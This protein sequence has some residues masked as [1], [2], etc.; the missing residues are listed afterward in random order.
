[1]LSVGAISA[2]AGNYYL[3]L[4]REDYYTKEDEKRGIWVGSGAD[5][6]NLKGEINEQEFKQILQGFSA[7]GSQKL[8]QNAG[9]DN[10]GCAWDL[11]FS[12]PKSVSIIFAVSDEDVRKVIEK[13][14]FEAV[15]E[16]LKEV[17]NDTFTR[18]GKGG[19]IYDKVD[20][21]CVAFEH[22]T[23][24]SVSKEVMPDMNLHTHI[25]VM[26]V[27]LSKSDGK[28]RSIKSENFYEKQQIYGNVYR[29]NLAKNLTLLNFECERKGEF[30]EVKGISKE[31]IEK[32]SKR[33]EQVKEQTKGIEDKAQKAKVK[34]RG[35]T[36][37]N[38]YNRKD[39]FSYWQAECKEFG[40]TSRDVLRLTDQERE[41]TKSVNEEAKKCLAVSV[42]KLTTKK[43]VFSKADL[44]K[45]FLQESTVHGIGSKD[46]KNKVNEFLQNKAFLVSENKNKDKT[47]YTLDKKTA[48]EE[49]KILSEKQDFK[50]QYSLQITEY[51]KSLEKKGFKVIGVSF[52]NETS[53]F[54]ETQTG[55]KTR[56]LRKTNYELQKG[57]ENK[58]DL[59]RKIKAEFKYA[60]YQISKDT[61]DKMLGLY[62]KPSSKSI[63]NLKY[64]TWQISKAH[65]NYLDYQL[66]REHFRVDEKTVVIF[67]GKYTEKNTEVESLF[68]QVE[69]E[70]GKVVTSA[71]IFQEQKQVQE[72]QQQQNQQAQAQQTQNQQQQQQQTQTQQT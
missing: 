59:K 28:T 69:A 47:L 63:H 9:K 60:T 27:G 19:K 62:H 33:T 23:S 49:K 67:D 58:I 48:F 36:V 31:L 53:K 3:N 45:E 2:G 7:D 24:R 57:F 40:L 34:L 54:F 4:S 21:V 37:K 51:K 35:R 22:S 13:A 42:A 61:K 12:A 30:F 16:T 66:E 71:E 64:A 43:P 44:E 18:L 39:L 15:K 70:G 10:R 1:M 26:N 50:K 72:Q 14:H 11:T 5:F 65:K 41:I 52:T 8:V 68:S 55:V 25:L 6:L 20:L 29:S 17:Q 56:T 38:S 46:A 32:F